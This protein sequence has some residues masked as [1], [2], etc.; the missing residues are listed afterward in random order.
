M[1]SWWV[2]LERILLVSV[3]G[4]MHEEAIIVQWWDKP[5]LGYPHVYKRGLLQVR[6]LG[7]LLSSSREGKPE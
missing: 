1:V 4:L 7:S 6:V 2:A 5:V 3:L